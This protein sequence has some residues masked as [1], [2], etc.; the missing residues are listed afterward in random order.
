MTE[1]PETINVTLSAPSNGGSVGSPST[2]TILDNDGAGVFQ[3]TSANFSVAEGT[4]V[5]SLNITRSGTSGSVTVR[6][7]PTGGS[8]TN[9]VDYTAPADVVFSTGVASGSCS[10]PISNDGVGEGSETAGFT[11][12]II[13]GAGASVSGQSTTTLTIVDN[14]GLGTVQFAAAN[15]SGFE[16]NGGAAIT[17]SRTVSTAGTV[18][19]DC[20]TLG[21]GTATANVDY[22]SGSYTATFGP[23]ATTATC[24]IPITNDFISEPLGETLTLGLANLSA[25]ATFGTTQLAIL[26]IFDNGTSAVTVT[27]LNPNSGPIGGGNSV[28]ITGT[29]YTAASTVTFGGIGASVVFNSVTQLTAVAPFNVAG[30]VDVVVTTPTLGSSSTVGTANDY[31]IQTARLSPMSRPTPGRPRVCRR[32]L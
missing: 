14:G 15:Y 8:A 21:G 25:G 13:S 9:G 6:C 2:V 10:V 18:T 30:T 3:F 5:A 31:R 1:G 27:G 24:T 20:Q 26:T 12:S 7:T 11:L 28:V 23:G 32:R 29:N 4:G 16:N 17:L 19:V 22:T